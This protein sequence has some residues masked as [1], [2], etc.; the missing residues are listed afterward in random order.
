MSAATPPADFSAASWQTGMAMLSTVRAVP[1]FDLASVP[2]PVRQKPEPLRRTFSGCAREMEGTFQE[3]GH[4]TGQL[5]RRA[6]IVEVALAELRTAYG[7]N[8]VRLLLAWFD[9]NVLSPSEMERWLAWNQ[10]FEAW[11]RNDASAFRLAGPPSGR[12]AELL[13]QALVPAFAAELAAREAEAVAIPLTAE[14]EHLLRVIEPEEGIDSPLLDVGTFFVLAALRER[15]HRLYRRLETQLPGEDWDR[16]RLA[17]REW[18]RQA[19]R[20]V[21]VDLE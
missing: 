14:D 21:A 1:L 17:A 4:W 20:G 19:T 15:A 10:F 13:G 11:A 5:G 6:A 12:A 8:A 2:E 16:L 18:R 3:P 7:D 9:R